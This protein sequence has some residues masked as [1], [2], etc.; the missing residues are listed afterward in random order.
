MRFLITG[1][2]RSGTGWAA[3]FFT[4]LGHQCY[5]ERVYAP[6]RTFRE[7]DAGESSWMA[8]PFVNHKEDRPVIRVVRDPYAVVSSIIKRGFLAQPDSPYDRFVKK[9]APGLMEHPDHLG[10]A[11]AYAVHWDTKLDEIPHRVVRVGHFNSPDEIEDLA[12][13]VDHATG[14]KHST[15]EVRGAL[16]TVGIVNANVFD[17]PEVTRQVID[18]HPLGRQVKLRAQRWNLCA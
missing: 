4:A 13:A 8:V 6:S 7:S 18:Q 10:R 11:I 5:H 15:S 9:Y 17:R 3:R 12:W 14:V 1:C 16:N 2:G